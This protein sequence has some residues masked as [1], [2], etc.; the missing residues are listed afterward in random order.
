MLAIMVAIMAHHLANY[1][2]FQRTHLK[3]FGKTSFIEMWYSEKNPGI[4]MLVRVLTACIDMLMRLHMDGQRHMDTD[5][6]YIHLHVIQWE[7]M[8]T[9]LYVYVCYILACT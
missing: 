6:S 9:K 2:L 7:I 8:M 5:N 4:Y 3:K 1:V